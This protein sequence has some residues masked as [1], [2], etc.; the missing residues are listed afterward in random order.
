M[1]RRVFCCVS[2]LFLKRWAYSAFVVAWKFF[3]LIELL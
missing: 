2:E 1:R 3:N